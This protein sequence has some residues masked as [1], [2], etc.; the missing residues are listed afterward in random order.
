MTIAELKERREQI[1]NQKNN[2]IAAA[3]KLVNTQEEKV[4]VENT[5]KVEDQVEVVVEEDIL[6]LVEGALKG[7][8]YASFPSFF[9]NKTLM[10]LNELPNNKPLRLVNGLYG[11]YK[12][13][14][15]DDFAAVCI[16]GY[17]GRFTFVNKECLEFMKRLVE[18]CKTKK[19]SMKKL[20]EQVKVNLTITKQLRK[21]HENEVFCVLQDGTNNWFYKYDW[22][23][24]R[25]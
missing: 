6:S 19:I 20:F 1:E 13:E 16:E 10:K 25:A 3:N 11:K 15:K 14:T 21:G 8:K 18:I 4:M 24:E 23:L 17:D 2:L 22:T 12:D 9:E 5:V 7:A